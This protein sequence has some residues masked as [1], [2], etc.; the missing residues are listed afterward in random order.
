MCAASI[1]DNQKN[2]YP[3]RLVGAHWCRKMIKK[4]RI[5]AYEADLRAVSFWLSLSSVSNKNVGTLR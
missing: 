2:M 1:S 5:F 3:C 4:A